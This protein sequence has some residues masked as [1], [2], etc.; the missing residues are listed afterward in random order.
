M[1]SDYT[2]KTIYQSDRLPRSS[3]KHSMSWNAE[4]V[5]DGVYMLHVRFDGPAGTQTKSTKLMIRR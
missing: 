4:G 3:G 5:A 2:G 1:I